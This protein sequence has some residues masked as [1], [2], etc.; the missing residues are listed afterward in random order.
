L[1]GFTFFTPNPRLADTVETIWDVDLPETEIAQAL[2]FKVLPAASPTICVHYRAPAG[3]DQRINPG[4]CRQR[5]TG[6]QTGTITI[7]PTGPVGAIIIHLKPEAAW[8]LT[9]HDM[10]AFTDANVGLRDL[11]GPVA[12]ARLE[13]MLG[14]AKDEFERASVIQ[15]F[16][17]GRIQ[18]HA[19]DALVRHAVLKIMRDPN[20]SVH[21]LAERLD[22][23]ERHLSRRFHAMVGTNV[24]R[25]ARLVRFGKAVAARRRGASWAHI[26][27]SCGYTDQAHLVREF[28]LI[29]G[30]PPEGL[31]KTISAAKYSELNSALALSGFSNTFVV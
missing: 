12:T 3:S 8:A 16:L 28:K 31:L 14:E 15:H 25:F 30:S 29:T 1:P 4:N 23:S 27:Y 17:L 2:S 18:Q 13:D 7:R 10:G 6:V 24:K 19:S 11:F 9:R 20:C 5:M 22:I 21:T 26:T